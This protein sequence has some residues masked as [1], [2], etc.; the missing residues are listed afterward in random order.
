MP[1]IQTG[2]PPPT[3]TAAVTQKKT[4]P[5]AS[6]NV[7]TAAPWLG[8][9]LFDVGSDVLG[10][11]DIVERPG[12][13]IHVAYIGLLRRGWDIH[14]F[15]FVGHGVSRKVH[16]GWVVLGRPAAAAAAG[17]MVVCHEGAVC[18]WQGMRERG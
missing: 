7:V 17:G 16:V 11:V 8:C 5:S 18:G 10:V 3:M 9:S 4:S 6:S 2:A 13:D 14:V 15:A 12:R 1:P